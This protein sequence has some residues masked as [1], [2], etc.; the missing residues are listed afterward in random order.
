[1][2]AIANGLKEPKTKLS[3]WGNYFEHLTAKMTSDFTFLATPVE[4][5]QI[6]FE[7]PI[8]VQTIEDGIVTNCNHDGAE[9]DAVSYDVLVNGFDGPDYAEITHAGLV[10]DK[11]P[12]WQSED[13]EWHE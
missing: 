2:N 4:V 7:T 10:C 12:A 13:G 6:T 1:M 9:Y 11:C 3:Q 8:T 5:K